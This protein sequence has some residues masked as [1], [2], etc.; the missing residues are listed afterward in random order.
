MGRKVFFK[1]LDGLRFFAFLSVFFAHSFYSKLEYISSE[2]LYLIF[3]KYA[4]SG[5]F[6]VYFFFVLSGFLITYL[7][8]QEKENHERINIKNFYVRRT[9]RIWPLYYLVVFVGFIIV[10]FIQNQ[11][12]NYSYEETGEL[13]PY[14]IF[15]TNFFDNSASA[16]LGVLWSISVEEQFYLVWPIIV[17]FVSRKYFL[18]LTVGIIVASYLW[19]SFIIYDFAYGHTFGC[20]SELCSGALLAYFCYYKLDKMDF[21]INLNKY[22]ILLIY[23]IGFGMIFFRSDYLSLLPSH[24]YINQRLF[25]GAYFSFIIFEQTYCKNSPYKISNIKILSNLGKITYGLYMLHFIVIYI[26]AKV[27]DILQLNT[28]LFQVLLVEP[29]LALILSIFVAKLSYK[30][31]EMPFLKFKEKFN[32]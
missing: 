13:W 15:I 26:T 28:S 11:L 25:Y 18:P 14:L 23:V 4:H 19:R 31:F 7:L 30:L 20:A 3:R 1:E 21:L 27:L 9:L 10:P 5:I 2:P 8:F 12:G 22:V 32:T 29:M 6:G 16:V 17:A 24:F